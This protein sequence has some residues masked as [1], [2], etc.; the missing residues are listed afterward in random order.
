MVSALIVKDRLPEKAHYSM[1]VFLHD[2]Q[3]VTEK[4]NLPKQIASLASVLQKGTSW[5]ISASGGVQM[6]CWQL[7]EKA[8]PSPDLTRH[9]KKR[10]CRQMAAGGGTD[11]GGQ[12]KARF[13]SRV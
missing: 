12:S 2:D 8:E 4:F 10:S 7:A 6:Y 13:T 5:L 11:V 1:S 9:A 3:L